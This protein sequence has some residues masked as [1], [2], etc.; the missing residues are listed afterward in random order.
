[1][2]AEHLLK[3][4]E[5]SESVIVLLVVTPPNLKLEFNSRVI[6]AEKDAHQAVGDEAEE[7][8]GSPGRHLDVPFLDLARFNICVKVLELRLANI[9][10]NEVNDRPTK[11]T[12]QHHERKEHGEA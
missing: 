10:T 8:D 1:M 7:A 4:L 6:G 5:A 2:I 3:D 12:S 9:F 11:K